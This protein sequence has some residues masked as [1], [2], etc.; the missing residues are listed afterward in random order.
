[1]GKLDA[2][3]LKP[4]PT[5]VFSMNYKTKE[6]LLTLMIVDIQTWVD[7][8]KMPYKP[9]YPEILEY[10]GTLLPPYWLEEKVIRE[11]GYLFNFIGEPSVPNFITNYGAMLSIQL[12]QEIFNYYNV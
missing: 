4:I 3:L 6:E 7:Y 5:P 10:S 12:Y 1:M 11:L 2:G 9:T 8:S